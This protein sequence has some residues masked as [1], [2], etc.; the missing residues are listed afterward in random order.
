VCR[1]PRQGGDEEILLDGDHEAKD[2][3][4]FDMACATISPDHRLLLWSEDSTG[5]EF[6]TLRVRDC[7]QGRDYEDAITESDGNGVW[8]AQ[9]QGFFYVRLDEHHRPSRVYYH[10]LGTHIDQD[11]LIYEEQ[12]KGWF[13]NLFASADHKWLIIHAHDHDSTENWLL[14]L[15]DMTAP[16]RLMTPRQRNVRSSIAP[17][18][19]TIFIKTNYDGAEDFKIVIAPL[20]QPEPAH[21]RDLIPHKAGTMIVSFAL[22]QNY[23]TRLE[24]ENGLPRLVVRHIESGREDVIAFPEEAYALSLIPERECATTN[25][26]F[27]YSSMTTQRQTYDYNMATGERQ[28]RKQQEIP[29]GHDPARYITRRLYARSHDGAQV[30][31]TLLYA[32]HTALTPDTPVFLTGYGAYGSPYPASFSEHRFSLVDRGFMYAIAHIRGGTDKGWAW[33]EQGKLAHKANSFKDFI[34]VARHLIKEGM[35]SPQRIIASGGSAGGMLMGAVAN[36]AP[37]LFAGIIADVPFVDV[38]NT[39]LDDSLP[40]TPPEWLEWGNPI[41]D[42][43]AFATMRA[44]SPY[45]NVRAQSYPAILAL[46]GLTDPRVTYW[47]PTKWVAR[48]RA[49]MTGGGPVLLKTNMKAGHGGASGRFDQLGDVALEYAFALACAERAWAAHD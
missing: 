13:L 35:T 28:L 48:L 38:I 18:G 24:R 25:L 8:D 9:T 3:P 45:D 47:E 21:W 5:S 40:L 10:A 20:N 30:P 29:S 44:Y 32:R 2:K 39:M 15:S 26:R 42:A 12:D 23:L 33:Y 1:M 19:D 43:E 14:S 6:Y 41:G 36:M 27:V 22:T 7:A 34:A 49:L 16:P 37:E 31:V 11:R 17:H 4:F 46:S